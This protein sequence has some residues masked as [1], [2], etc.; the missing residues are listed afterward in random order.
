[1]AKNE[2][3]NELKKVLVIPENKFSDVEDETEI[4][5][6]LEKVEKKIVDLNENR[7]EIEEY[8]HK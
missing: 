8:R 1:M 4:E 7:I 5:I 2:F 6:K 3:G